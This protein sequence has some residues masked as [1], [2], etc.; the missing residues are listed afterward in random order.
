MRFT[1]KAYEAPA[2]QERQPGVGIEQIDQAALAGVFRDFGR[3]LTEP[4]RAVMEEAMSRITFRDADRESSAASPQMQR[5]LNELVLADGSGYAC[6]FPATAPDQIEIWV[7]H[8]KLAREAHIAEAMLHINEIRDL[9]LDAIARAL[10]MD[11][12]A[13]EYGHSVAQVTTAHDTAGQEQ[14][15]SEGLAFAEAPEEDAAFLNTMI[16]EGVTEKMGREAARAYF[17]RTGDRAALRVLDALNAITVNSEEQTGFNARQLEVNMVNAFV[18]YL[19]EMWKEYEADRDSIWRAIV[20]GYLADAQACRQA[21]QEAVFGADEAAAPKAIR[22]VFKKLH[23]LSIWG[24][25]ADE[26]SMRSLVQLLRKLNK[27]TAPPPFFATLGVRQ[28]RPGA[29][30]DKREGH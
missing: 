2:P 5:S 1:G 20:R 8:Q 27:Q 14:V 12:V 22:E 21:L 3:G 26:A 19:A 13:H 29:L 15:L 7:A 17:E 28:T 9:P 25:P 4:E 10:L 6:M 30:P 18:E 11:A 24:H 16:D 23:D